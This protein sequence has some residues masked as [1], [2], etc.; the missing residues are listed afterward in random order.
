[1]IDEAQYRFTGHHEP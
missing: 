1:M